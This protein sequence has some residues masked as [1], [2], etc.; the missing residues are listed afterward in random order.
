MRE[1]QKTPEVDLTLHE[2]YNAV[3]AKGSMDII[4]AK[5]SSHRSVEA[6]E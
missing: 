3:R 4:P 5:P 2:G 6:L 1:K